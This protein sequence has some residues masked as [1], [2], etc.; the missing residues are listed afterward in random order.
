M[1]TRNVSVFVVSAFLEI[2]GCFA[3][4]VWLRCGG[5]PLIALAGIGSLVG[6]AVA[7]TRA[8]GAF[9]G[10]AY[11]AYGGIYLAA[12]LLWLWRIEGQRP[13]RPTF[14]ELCSPERDNGQLLRGLVHHEFEPTNVAAID[15][16]GTR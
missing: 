12:S 4:W 13:M 16:A 14:S 7:L 15:D 11:A 3:F 5:W 8:D 10:R 6:F 9:G 1:I 2:A